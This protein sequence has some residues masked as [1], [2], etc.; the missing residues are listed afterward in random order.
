MSVRVI[1]GPEPGPSATTIALGSRTDPV[2]HAGRRAKYG[3][4]RVCG[5]QRRLA[6]LIPGSLATVMSEKYKSRRRGAGPSVKNPSRTAPSL[7]Q[8]PRW[9]RFLASSTSEALPR[10]LHRLCGLETSSKRRTCDRHRHVSRPTR[11][12]PRCSRAHSRVSAGSAAWG[13][14]PDAG[15]AIAA[16]RRTVRSSPCPPLP[17]VDRPVSAA[18][19]HDLIRSSSRTPIA[20]CSDSGRC[21][22]QAPLENPEKRPS[23]RSATCFP[24]GYL[25]AVVTCPSPASPCPTARCRSVRHVARRSGGRFSTLSYGADR[26]RSSTNTR[27]GRWRYT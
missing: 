5:S 13:T 20:A 2:G 16:A 19:D 14:S 26:V 18:V 17:E 22:T 25:S 9:A 10:S 3:A 21:A 23:V 4:R 15:R 11:R 12:S 27:A 6:R 7:A 24:R 1:A 8:E